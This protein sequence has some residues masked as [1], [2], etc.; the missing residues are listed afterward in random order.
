MLIN[1]VFIFILSF[2]ARLIFVIFFPD[3]GGDYEIYSTVAKNII[4]GCGVS[5]SDPMS[6]ECVPH[7]GGNHG[8]G[9]DV[10]IASIWYV[11]DHSNNAVRIIQTLIYS[12]FCIY[13]LV[14]IKKH[15]DN[16]KFLTFFG[17]ILSLSPLL[18]AWPRY[19]Q[20]ETLAIAFT[21]FLIAELLLS[22]KD[23]KIR[24]FSIALALILAT[25]IRLDN[26][27]LTIPVAVCCFYFHGVKKGFLYGFLIAF[28]LSLSWGMWT[29]RNIIV[30]L[31]SL[32]PT[33]MIMPDGS[34]SPTGYLSWTKTWI[35]D[36]YEKPG[37]LWGI[38][39]KNYANIL[40]P[41][42]AYFDKNEKIKIE[43]LVYKLKKLD[44]LPFPKEID[45][46][47]KQEAENKKNKYPIKYWI[48]N[49]IKRIYKMWSNP[50][51]SFGWPNEI[52]SEGL[53]HSERLFVAKGN[54][55]ILLLKIK[56]NPYSSISKGA[57]A[58]YKFT[59]FLLFMYSLFFLFIKTEKKI[60]QFFGYISLSYLLGRT[61]FFSI[62]GIFETRYIVTVIPFM[63]LFVALCLFEKY[64]KKIDK[65]SSKLTTEK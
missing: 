65:F 49:P 43:K 35:T 36:E 40:I 6:G 13:L 19:V 29:T 50:F 56:K 60:L 8:P 9:Y 41:E 25:W 59:L 57:N 51:S 14:A 31:P 37:S 16:K 32:V 20:T 38:N 12:S 33:N 55:N 27:F 48:Q 42:Y 53:S 34:R 23:K 44:G 11:F 54:F 18:I 61:M 7:F 2:L 47:F 21:L 28:L 3:T 62:N 24:V 26:I 22:L 10:F 5:L 63:E 17:I 39:R 46:E 4:R 58:L 15:I 30:K 52:P 64:Y 1:F 45:D